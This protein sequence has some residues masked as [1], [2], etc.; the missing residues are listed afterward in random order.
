MFQAIVGFSLRQ[1]VFVLIA[2]VILVAWGSWLAKDMPI[3]LFP[4]IRQ[5]SVIVI[6]EAP[7]LA[8]QE[9]AVSYTHL[10]LPTILRV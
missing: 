3:D 1:R 8:A 5:P 10:T 2:A 9:T 7:G 4:E 6:A